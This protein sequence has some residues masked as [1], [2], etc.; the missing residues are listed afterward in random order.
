M[1]DK[2]RWVEEGKGR[3]RQGG[4]RDRTPDEDNR[5]GRHGAKNSV[6]GRQASASSPPL[7]YQGS[8]T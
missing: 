6:G 1:R 5:G 7:S 3:C 4:E 2:N 8:H